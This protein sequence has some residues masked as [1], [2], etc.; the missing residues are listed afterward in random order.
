[1]LS[2]LG[3]RLPRVYSGAKQTGGTKLETEVLH[4]FIVY[5]SR[6]GLGIEFYEAGSW[7]LVI[8]KY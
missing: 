6:L 7:F 5:N 2:V 1:M 8:G 3:V 4:S